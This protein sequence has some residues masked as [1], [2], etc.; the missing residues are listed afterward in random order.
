MVCCGALIFITNATHVDVWLLANQARAHAGMQHC[1]DSAF[2]SDSLFRNYKTVSS[3]SS[4]PPPLLSLSLSLFPRKIDHQ[5]PGQS[6]A[7]EAGVTALAQ[8]RGAGVTALAQRRGTG[9]T[10]PVQ[11]TE[12]D[13]AETG[14]GTGTEARTG[15]DVRVHGIGTEIVAGE[16][17]RGI[18]TGVMAAADGTG[19]EAT[20]ETSRGHGRGRGH[21]REM[22]LRH[23]RRWNVTTAR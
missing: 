7:T 9:V 4:H 19:T 15:A 12:A 10:G 20:T 1:P 8:R 18:G 13:V 11:G 5:R 16:T 17:A 2:C 21:Q 14:S 6:R 23:G 3:H 22:L